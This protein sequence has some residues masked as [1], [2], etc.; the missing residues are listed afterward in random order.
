MDTI[1]AL[2]IDIGNAVRVV[3]KCFAGG[4]TGCICNIL[5]AIKPSWIDVLPSPQQ[6][7]SGGNIFGLLASKILEMC[8]R[9]FPRR[10]QPTCPHARAQP[11]CAGPCKRPRTRSTGS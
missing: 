8:A 6:R 5:L 11:F 1:E 2:S 10:A 7:C 9:S 4:F 3:Q